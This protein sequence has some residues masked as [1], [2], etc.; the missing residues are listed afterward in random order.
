MSISPS[1]Q[2]VQIEH[3][4]CDSLP[5]LAQFL[6]RM[7]TGKKPERP[8]TCVSDLA[9]AAVGGVWK[10]LDKRDPGQGVIGAIS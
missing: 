10:S 8:R 1:S 2:N 6:R 5:D 3:F 4:Q 9:A 7:M